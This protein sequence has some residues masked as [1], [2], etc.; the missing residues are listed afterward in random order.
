MT[1]LFLYLNRLSVI[2]GPDLK[3]VKREATCSSKML[4]SHTR[5]HH[6]AA[7]ETAM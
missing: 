6:I 3:N 2:V 5:L 7:Q 4:V 1:K